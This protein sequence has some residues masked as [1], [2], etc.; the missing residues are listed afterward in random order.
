MFP[1]RPAGA[2]GQVLPRR[3]PGR[4]LTLEACDLFPVPFGLV[5]KPLD[6]RAVVLL[7]SPLAEQAL[8]AAKVVL[9]LATVAALLAQPAVKRLET[10]AMSGRRSGPERAGSYRLPRI[11]STRWMLEFSISRLFFG[12]PVELIEQVQTR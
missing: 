3:R 7:S 12:A 11:P 1:A 2:P 6:G 8:D 4:Q 9:R 5:D 10:P